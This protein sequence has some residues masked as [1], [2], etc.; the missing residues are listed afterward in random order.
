MA[1][2]RV[3]PALCALA[4]AGM[5]GVA[6]AAAA[7]FDP[8]H[9][10]LSS[11]LRQ[12][13]REARVDYAALKAAPADLDRYL[14]QLASVPREEF[15]SWEPP[16]RIAFLLNAYNAWTLRLVAT[17]YPVKS[18]KE[19][20]TLL[21]GP[22]DQRIVNLFGQTVSL[23]TLEHQVLRKEYNEP[24]LHFALVCA[25]RSC[26]P[27]RDEA[28]V[29]ERL[30][31]QLD[32]QARRFLATASKNRV[33]AGERT[34]YLSPL[35]KWYAGDFEKNSGSVLAALQS[36]WPKDAAAALEKGGFKIRYTEYDW[37]LNDPPPR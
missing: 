34:V 21:S 30:S 25:A 9:A 12:H 6:C 17:H 14:A 18:I 29:G 36:Y 20:G 32:D 24:R 33:V 16:A 22:W 10:L 31:G 15:K 8:S 37:S 28:Y 4:L 26:P 5:A 2:A 19:I 11:V 23:D 7:A 35:F 3:L 27:L 1:A 13:V